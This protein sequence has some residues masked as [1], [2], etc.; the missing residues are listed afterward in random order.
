MCFCKHIRVVPL[1][2]RFRFVLECCSSFSF[3]VSKL[4]NERNIT[5][6]EDFRSF[7]ARK[8]WICR[9]RRRMD[10]KLINLKVELNK[11]SVEP[12]E[13]VM[14]AFYENFKALM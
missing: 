4:L 5:D 14:H 10:L 1:I 9:I 2:H 11:M 7:K 13:N 6:D 12:C 8:G 3:G